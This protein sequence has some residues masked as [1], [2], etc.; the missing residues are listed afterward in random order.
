M[1][2]IL[3]TDEPD[4][5]LVLFSYW[6]SAFSTYYVELIGETKPLTL[7]MAVGSPWPK[8]FKVRILTSG[9]IDRTSLRNMYPPPC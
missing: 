1:S 7:E 8:Q 3:V 2:R 9:A 5:T 4:F 6:A